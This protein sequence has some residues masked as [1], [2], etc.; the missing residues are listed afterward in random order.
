MQTVGEAVAAIGRLDQIIPE[1][2]RAYAALNFSLDKMIESYIS[3]YHK[4]INDDVLVF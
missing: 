1:K 4:V 3:A 2:C